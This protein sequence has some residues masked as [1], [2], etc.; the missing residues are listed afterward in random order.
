MT[1]ILNHSVVA[2]VRESK[3]SYDFAVLLLVGLLVLGLLIVIVA[4]APAP[5]QESIQST[6]VW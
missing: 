3:K 1:D 6:L 5:F 4:N 2:R